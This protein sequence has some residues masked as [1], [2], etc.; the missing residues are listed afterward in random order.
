MDGADWAVSEMEALMENCGLRWWGP[1]DGGNRGLKT[2]VLV[3]PGVGVRR[4]VACIMR[5]E[6][7]RMVV[8][9]LG[10]RG[11]EWES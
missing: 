1:L 10:R 4:R 6:G 5:R 7:E 2:V 9:G 8:S 11:G 3:A